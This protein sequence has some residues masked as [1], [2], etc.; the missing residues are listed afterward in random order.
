MLFNLEHDPS[1]IVDLYD[2]QQYKTIKETMFKR[3]DDL[4]REIEW[5]RSLIKAG[6]WKAMP[7]CNKKCFENLY[8]TPRLCCSC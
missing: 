2:K 1:E 7:C 3:K 4:E 8:S 6:S 5:G